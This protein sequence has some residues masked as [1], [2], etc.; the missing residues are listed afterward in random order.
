MSRVTMQLALDALKS[1]EL[2]AFLN[3][4]TDF[5]K[6]IE[7]IEDELAKPDLETQLAE[8]AE[9]HATAMNAAY[10]EIERLQKQLTQDRAKWFYR[11]IAGFQEAV[12]VEREA[13]AKLCDNYE[14]LGMK[15]GSIAAREIALSIRAR[16]KVE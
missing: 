14:P 6:L 3:R 12:E 5:R 11:G 8:E 15:E 9:A 1:V 16:S 13:C 2:L 7:S 10:V 4:G